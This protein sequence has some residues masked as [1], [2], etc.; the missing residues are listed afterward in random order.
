VFAV[1]IATKTRDTGKNELG[2]ERLEVEDRAGVKSSR[3]GRHV[4]VLH[5]K[6]IPLPRTIDRDNE[7]T[8]STTLEATMTP[9]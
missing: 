2:V 9:Y 7:D 4:S 8:G 5:C 3:T 1:S 6:S